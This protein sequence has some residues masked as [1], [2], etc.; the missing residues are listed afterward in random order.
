MPAIY[1]FGRSRPPEMQRSLPLSWSKARVRSNRV[2]HSRARPLRLQAR[3]AGPHASCPEWWWLPAND[4]QVRGWKLTPLCRLVIRYLSF[5]RCRRESTLHG[6]DPTN[7]AWRRAGFT[8]APS[9]GRVGNSC[10]AP[11][12]RQRLPKVSPPH[13]FREQVRDVDDNQLLACP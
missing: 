10:S 3:K 6:A 7:C 13:A 5:P 11:Q 8:A 4:G 2:R 12:C 9:Q 1:L